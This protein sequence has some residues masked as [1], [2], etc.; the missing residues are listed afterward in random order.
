MTDDQQ[1]SPR[2]AA[3]VAALRRSAV[4]IL[5]LAATGTAL[6]VA[7]GLRRA[8]DHT[9]QASILVSPLDGNPFYPSGRGDDLINLE[10]EAQLMQSDSVANA[11]AERIGDPGSASD[12]LSGLD[13]S[14]PAN[15]QILTINYTG[16]SDAV[17]VRR[18][19]GFAEAYLDFRKARS[20]AVT[21]AKTERI[22]NQINSQDK[23]LSALVAK[24]NAET[25]PAQKSLLQEQVSG[26]TSQIGQLQ[27]ALAELQ[28]GSV[29]PGQV[30]TP[31]AIVGRSSLKAL[32][33]Y[34]LLGMFA[35]LLLA[36]GIVIIRARSENRIHHADD[37]AP[38]GLPLLGSVSMDEVL[39]TNEGIVLLEDGESLQIGSGLAAL[40][41]AVLSG[42]R[43]R[44]VRILYSAAAEAARYPRTALGL[45]Y[46]AAASNLR[47]V[48]V[49]ATGE[50]GDITKFLN[51]DTK[52]G[53][54]DVLAE[55]SSAAQSL[56]RLTDH[57]SILPSGK[58]DPRADDLLT[59]PG[60][61]TVFDELGQ[62]FDIIVVA[63]GPR[64]T[65]QAQALAMVTDVTVVEAV[66]SKSRLGDL[67]ALADDPNAA[68]SVLG[69]V[70]VGR[71][72]SRSRRHAE[73]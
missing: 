49:D 15:T 39:D 46:A 11:V 31:A 7:A 19:Q 72:R 56:V 43:R 42:D 53:F 21:R 52:R 38:S 64:R 17:A 24:A 35:G 8:E 61:K 44:P 37:V 23:A 63:A 54:T 51:L 66:E 26:V 27:A 10:T 41:V 33:A 18:A 62:S 30:I 60:I 22:Q 25:V 2:R 45:A 12:L 71:A 16:G 69:V 36:L 4:L 59:G 47:T 70:F 57:L 50:G 55:G 28:T 29:D 34:A 6:G 14:V 9:A 3:L 1:T 58:P 32:L 20:E 5:V 65:P 48:V 68:P 13:V 73:A 40:R 67:V